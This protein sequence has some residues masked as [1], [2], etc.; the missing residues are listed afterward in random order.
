M[1]GFKF[2]YIISNLLIIFEKILTKKKKQ[3]KRSFFYFLGGGLWCQNR[4][5]EKQILWCGWG[6]ILTGGLW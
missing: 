6:N 3:K 5:G 2:N 4:T 1:Y